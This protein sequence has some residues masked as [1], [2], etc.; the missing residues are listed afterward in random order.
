MTASIFERVEKVDTL[1][2]DKHNHCGKALFCVF[3]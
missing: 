1:S 3:P 2:E